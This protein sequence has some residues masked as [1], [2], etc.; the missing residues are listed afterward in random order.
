[1][2]RAVEN[3]GAAQAT[4]IVDFNSD[5]LNLFIFQRALLV[6]VITCMVDGSQKRSR[7]AQLPGHEF[8]PEAGDDFALIQTSLLFSFKCQVV[9]L[10]TT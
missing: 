10:R 8:K 1:M 5:F 4:V 9:S 7:R 2:S 6:V 3:E